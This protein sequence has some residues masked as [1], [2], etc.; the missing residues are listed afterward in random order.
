MLPRPKG[1]QPT[2]EEMIEAFKEVQRLYEDDIL[3]KEEKQMIKESIDEFTKP[4]LKPN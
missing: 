3:P 4:T 2:C 1:R